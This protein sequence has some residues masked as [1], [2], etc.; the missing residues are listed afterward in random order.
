MC[1]IIIIITPTV[2]N[3]HIKNSGAFFCIQQFGIFCT[4]FFSIFIFLIYIS[5]LLFLPVPCTAVTSEFPL[6]GIK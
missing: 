2:L 3:I 1:I 5:N 4:L 6:H